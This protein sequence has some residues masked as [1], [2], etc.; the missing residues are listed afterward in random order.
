MGM[1]A[2]R[3][4]ISE[5]YENPLQPKDF[6]RLCSSRLQNAT[7][8]KIVLVHKSQWV[9][10]L[11]VPTSPM[12]PKKLSPQELVRLCLDSQD[13]AS[14]T[15]F[16]RRFQPTIAGAVTKWLLHRIRRANPELIDDLVQET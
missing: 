15:E 13:Q 11:P 6:L 1:V 14:W 9:K 3:P 10:I 4:A 7:A 2:H 8:T 16:V 5:D 12:D